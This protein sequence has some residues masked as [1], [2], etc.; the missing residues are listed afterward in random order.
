MKHACS[1]VSEKQLT[2]ICRGT[3]H[4]AG[5]RS[6]EMFPKPPDKSRVRPSGCRGFVDWPETGFEEVMTS[7]SGPAV[8]HSEVVPSA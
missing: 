8:G 4:T 7:G 5:L 2:S 1:G 3:N 6:I